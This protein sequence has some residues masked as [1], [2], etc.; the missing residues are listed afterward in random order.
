MIN[1]LIGY[2]STRMKRAQPHVKSAVVKLSTS[3]VLD[4]DTY[5]KTVKVF[6]LGKHTCPV[7]SK[8]EKPTKKVTSSKI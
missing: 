3:L 5:K 7:I 1:R 6:Y 2:R 8:P 4:D